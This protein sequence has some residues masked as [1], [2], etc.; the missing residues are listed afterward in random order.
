MGGPCQAVAVMKTRP[1]NEQ[2]LWPRS[3]GP[4]GVAGAGRT[5]GSSTIFSSSTAT[6]TLMSTTELS[7]MKTMKKIDAINGLTAPALISSAPMMS[8]RAIASDHD[9][10]V[11]TWWRRSVEV[12]GCVHA[13]V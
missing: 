13:G 11:S 6:T 7:R 4:S 8:G 12:C 10:P 2:G 9:S 1:R 3:P 5:G